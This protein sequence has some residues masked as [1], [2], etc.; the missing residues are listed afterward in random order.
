MQTENLEHYRQ[1]AARLHAA[2]DAEDDPDL[3]SDIEWAAGQYD[4]LVKEAEGL[5][6]G[7]KRPF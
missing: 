3:K 5:A 4:K 1:Q 7:R 6:G 2:A